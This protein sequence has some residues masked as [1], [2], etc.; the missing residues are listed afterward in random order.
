M[1]IRSKQKQQGITLVGLIFVLIVL[2]GIGVLALKV[3]PTVSEYMTIKK[4]IVSA[5]AAG[6]TPA[7]IRSSFDRNA[8]VGYV[9]SISGKD[10]MI[11]PGDNGLEVS[12]DY[13]KIIPLVG[14]ASLMIAYQGS[15]STRPLQRN[16]K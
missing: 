2:G 5:K 14:P 16:A 11:E 12:F 10:L 3:F 7:E 1:Q 15:T 9:T 4:A 13:Q 8:D 6:S